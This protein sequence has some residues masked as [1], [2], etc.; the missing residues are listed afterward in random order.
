MLRK[1]TQLP[2]ET[3]EL[4]K[5][6]SCL[7]HSFSLS[8]LGIITHQSLS[9]L[10]HCLEPVVAFSLVF[11]VGD[12][13][14]FAHDRVQEA[15][16]SLLSE[17]DKKIMHLKIGRLLLENRAKG[18]DGNSSSTSA[19]GTSSSGS[20]PLSSISSTS[21][22]KSDGHTGIFSIADHFNQAVDLV[23]DDME[24]LK[25]GTTSRDK[26]LITLW[27]LLTVCLFFVA[28]LNLEASERA[29]HAI[30]YKA[31]LEYL[32]Y[33]LEYVK[34]IDIWSEH[35]SFAFTVHKSAA[36][37]LYLNTQFEQSMK[38]IEEMLPFVRTAVDKAE[39]YNLVIIQRTIAADYAG[40]L[41]YGRTA[42]ELLGIPL[43][44]NNVQE[45]CQSFFHFIGVRDDCALT[46]V[47]IIIII[48]IL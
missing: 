14:Y 8:T 33:G 22:E 23:T 34:N 36:E 46:Y 3:Q 7:G 40:A 30:A 26:R 41:D 11:Q 43:P 12:I 44:S 10:A 16:Y 29:K 19:S 4:M 18:S 39:V 21:S 42:L 48:I 5:I 15:F 38:T 17:S 2:I 47:I 35:Y 6:C 28:H 20:S 45:V 27:M 13:F 25:L 32:Q 31:A 1:I 9:E 37:L 24:R